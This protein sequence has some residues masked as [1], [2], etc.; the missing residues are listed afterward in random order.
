MR[1][2]H[3]WMSQMTHCQGAPSGATDLFRRMG[4]R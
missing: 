3:L 1:G 4:I 2:G